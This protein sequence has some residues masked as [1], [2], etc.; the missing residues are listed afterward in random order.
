M[1]S[2]LPPAFAWAPSQGSPGLGKTLPHCCCS[3]PP[4][5]PPLCSL[6]FPRVW[7]A[8]SWLWKLVLQPGALK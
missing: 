3:P 6:D 8:T 4:P 2:P 7:G 5:L 1:A